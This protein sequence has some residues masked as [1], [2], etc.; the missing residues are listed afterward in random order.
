MAQ[1]VNRVTDEE[2]SVIHSSNQD[3]LDETSVYEDNY[4]LEHQP[5]DAEYMVPSRENTKLW[6]STS[7]SKK[8]EL[9]MTQM[10]P[11]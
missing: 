10:I 3:D 4:T 8:S 2:P 7:K 6:Q 11:T 1:A 9:N 5:Y